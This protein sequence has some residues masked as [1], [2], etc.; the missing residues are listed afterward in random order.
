M[1]NRLYLFCQG[2]QFLDVGRLRLPCPGGKQESAF[3]MQE[4]QDITPKDTNKAGIVFHC[5]ET[6]QTA[7]LYLFVLL[8]SNVYVFIYPLYCCRGSSLP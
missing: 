2:H 7:F 5:K 1:A 3:C 4:L 6:Q 8:L